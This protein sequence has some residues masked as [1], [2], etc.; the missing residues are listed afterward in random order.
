MKMLNY[1]IKNEAKC[2]VILNLILI[3]L[4]VLGLLIVR[5][6]RAIS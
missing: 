1:T 3:L 6:A 4:G 5:L 2:I